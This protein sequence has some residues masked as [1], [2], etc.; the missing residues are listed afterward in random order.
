MREAQPWLNNLDKSREYA[1]VFESIENQNRL[2]EQQ[3]GICC[4]VE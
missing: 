4:L 3:K 2:V 1:E